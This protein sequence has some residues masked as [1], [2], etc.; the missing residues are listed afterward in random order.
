MVDPKNLQK[1]APYFGACWPEIGGQSFAIFLGQP[2]L[3]VFSY[4]KWAL[5]IDDWIRSCY[6]LP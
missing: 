4:K 5:E 3:Q 6:A 1:T 2:L